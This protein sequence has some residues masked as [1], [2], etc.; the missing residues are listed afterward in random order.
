MFV[1]SGRG[2]SDKENY[3][4]A[5]MGVSNKSGGVFGCAGEHGKVKLKRGGSG[6]A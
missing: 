3:E 6:L 5:S 1:G 2:A 4:G